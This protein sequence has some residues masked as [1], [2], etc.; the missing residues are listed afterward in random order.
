MYDF[1]H[2]LKVVAHAE[3]TYPQKSRT[4]PHRGALPFLCCPPRPREQKSSKKNSHPY[5][6]GVRCGMIPIVAAA[7]SAV[8]LQLPKAV[9]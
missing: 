7:C 2:S 5:T 4:P 8:N 3:R 6:S 1:L 9:A